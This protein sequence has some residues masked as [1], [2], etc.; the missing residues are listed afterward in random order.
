M[1]I[2]DVIIIFFCLFSFSN[3]TC[4]SE[5]QEI[6]IRG[7]GDCNQR[8]FNEEETNNGAYKCCFLKEEIDT[9]TQKGTRY[10]CVAISQND[11]NNIKDVVKQYKSHSGVDDVSIKCKSSYL[12]YGLFSLILLLL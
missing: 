1:K 12:Q 7:K 6:K 9:I 4:S 5:D 10:T 8:S 3:L 2:I 11:Y